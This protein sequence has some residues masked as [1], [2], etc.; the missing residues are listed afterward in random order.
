MEWKRDRCAIGR[1]SLSIEPRSRSH[2]LLRRNVT[3]SHAFSCVQSAFIDLAS[4]TVD[5]NFRNVD[6]TESSEPQG[7]L[8]SALRILTNIPRLVLKLVYIFE[9]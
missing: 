5:V 9:D 6:A 4:Q 7:T 3:M 8:L 2:A 1:S